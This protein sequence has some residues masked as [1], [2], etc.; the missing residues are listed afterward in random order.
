[1]KPASTGPGINLG[2]NPFLRWLS[3]LG[4]ALLLVAA[5]SAPAE[6]SPLRIKAVRLEGTNVMVE[7]RVPA[8]LSE[9]LLESRS[10]LHPSGWQLRATLAVNGSAATNVIFTL[11][12]SSHDEFLRV[13]STQGSNPS[14]RVVVFGD[15]LSDTGRHFEL[16]DSPLTPP[17]FG[18]RYS[19]GPVWI[20]YLVKALGLGSNQ[21]IN[22][23]VGGAASGRDNSGSHEDAPGLLDEIDQFLADSPHLRVDTNALY[24][25]WI[26]AND[27]A[28]WN[29]TKAFKTTSP[30]VLIEGLLTNV[31]TA[32][33]TLVSRGAKHFLIPNLPDL[34]RIPMI[35]N[36]GDAFA[37]PAASLG[38]LGFNLSLAAMLS[39]LQAKYRSNQVDF[40]QFDVFSLFDRVL[41]RPA[42]FGLTD[43]RN[44]CWPDPAGPPCEQPR[45]HLFWDDRHPTTTVHS[46]IAHFA[47]LVLRAGTNVPPFN[48]P[49]PAAADPTVVLT[50]RDGTFT[51]APQIEVTGQVAGAMPPDAALTVNSMPVAPDAGGRFAITLPLDPAALANPV[52]AEIRRPTS[53]SPAASTQL[54]SRDRIVIYHGRSVSAG[55]PVHNAVVT[56]A[57]TSGL[58]ALTEYI[59]QRLIQTG[60]LNLAGKLPDPDPVVFFDIPCK[61]GVDI[62][63]TGAGYSCVSVNAQPMSD[64]I[65]VWLGLSDVFVTYGAHG[66]LQDCPD[67]GPNCF[68]SVYSPG[69][70]GYIDFQIR[71]TGGGAGQI[72]VTALTDFI[73]GRFQVHHQI[74]DCNHDFNIG[75]NILRL[76]NPLLEKLMH[77]ELQDRLTQHGGTQFLA[78]GLSEGIN[79]LA[80]RGKLGGS[81]DA[82]ISGRIQGLESRSGQL[83]A[84]FETTVDGA[85]TAGLQTYAGPDGNFRHPVVTPGDGA[86]YDFAASV[87]LGA[88]NQLILTAAA[89]IPSRWEQKTIELGAGPQPITAS[90]LSIFFPALRHEAR[91]TSYKLVIERPL[92]P[93]LVGGATETCP[94]VE[95]ALDNLLLSI[96]RT[97]GSRDEVVLTAA[98]DLRACVTF[99]HDRPSSSLVFGLQFSPESLRRLVLT[100]NKICADA[101]MLERVLRTGLAAAMNAL[102]DLTF[103]FQLPHPE[104]LSITPVQLVAESGYVSAYAALNPRHGRPDLVVAEVIVPDAVDVNYSFP[105]RV[106]V[107]NVGFDTAF[108]SVGIGASL[109]TDDVIWNG[110]DL[111][112]GIATFQ[113]SG[114]SLRPNESEWFTFMAWQAPLAIEGTQRLFVGVDVPDV[115]GTAGAFCEVN[116][117]NNQFSRSIRT[118]R[119]DAYVESVEAP[120]GLVGGGLD[121][122][123]RVR[124]GRNDVGIDSMDVPVRVTIGEGENL[125]WGDAVARVPRGGVTTVLVRVSTPPAFGLICSTAFNT[126][127]VLA[128]THLDYDPNQGNNCK[129]TTAQVAVPYYN[130]RYT[131]NGPSE[132]KVGEAVVWSVTIHNDGNMPSPPISSRTAIGLAPGDD[133]LS[134]VNGSLRTFVAPVLA[135]K[136]HTGDSATV[137]FSALVTPGAVVHQYIKAGIDPF[138]GGQDPCLSGNQVDVPIEICGADLSITDIEIPDDLVGGDG[139]RTYYVTVQNNGCDD[140]RGVWVKTCLGQVCI[141]VGPLTIKTNASH[142]FPVRI[143]TPFSNGAAHQVNQFPIT[144]CLTG[145]AD[146]TPANNCR[147]EQAPIAVPFFDLQFEII[148]SGT[149]A[150]VCTKVDWQVKVTN[151]GNIRSPQVCAM[152]GVVK[153][154]GATNWFPN[155]GQNFFQVVELD[156]NRSWTKQ[157][158]DY[159]IWCQPSFVGPGYIKAE[160]NYSNRCFDHDLTGNMAQ[161]P[162]RVRY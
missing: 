71:S 70:Q 16:Y 23:S 128:C 47:A 97:G 17:S 157:I 133:Y 44:A 78:D 57:N 146:A 134:I 150:Y 132:A 92:L 122:F 126:Y 131:I 84:R 154:S 83:E 1:M 159:E 112:L 142:R 45:T 73:F 110:N 59:Q 35:Q 99:K 135:A 109:S 113:F 61:P 140:A 151:R 39:D 48:C 152:T 64:R 98:L 124:V 158:D 56:T 137:S 94:G 80:F 76:I 145:W 79:S 63:F 50:T 49:E 148:Y 162:F 156:P 38:T 115:P 90:L 28:I 4:P 129:T 69:I 12:R 136:G 33:E 125:R 22:H 139:L 15:S 36:S 105:I 43:V 118:T 108:G 144:A 143:V 26:G 100:E 82:I 51:T 96:V 72:Q 153:P 34:G 114:G 55:Q 27:F 60:N 13:R 107:K 30:D 160:I 74:F 123:Y 103:P 75:D 161:K 86:E 18:G 3:L 127:T 106:R 91:E 25:L 19:D 111:R 54:L 87:S 116:E 21:W 130:L 58:D 53:A 10:D 120:D 8:G 101:A 5:V 121:G 147:T 88:V 29:Q 155:L 65:R 102:T 32:V 89:R 11:P 117:F 14:L 66:W 41:S 42:D 104:D 40:V 9:V 7:A 141:D 31:R 85:G 24:V 119:A 20:E 138:A 93:M 68:G 95:A 62:W 6:F 67:P 46:N 77:D 2:R 81:L 52:L 149:G 37:M